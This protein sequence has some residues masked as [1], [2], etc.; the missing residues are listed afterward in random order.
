[1]THDEV[2]AAMKAE[3]VECPVSQRVDG[4]KHSWVWASDG[5]YVECHYCGELQDAMGGTVI[6]PGRKS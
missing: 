5:P 6:T 2:T 3:D 1:M 4:K